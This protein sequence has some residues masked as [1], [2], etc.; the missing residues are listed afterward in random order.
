[1]YKYYRLDLYTVALSFCLYI[2][3]LST[4]IEICV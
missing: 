4:N 2:L 1:M 3:I